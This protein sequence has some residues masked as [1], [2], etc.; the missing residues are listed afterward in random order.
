MIALR[1]VYVLALVVWLGGTV[2]IGGVV[3]PAAFAALEAHDPAGGRT[4]AAVVVGEVLRRF[5]VVSWIALPALL[6]TLIAM[7]LVGPRP[8]GFGVR[9]AIVSVL[10]ALSLISG[11][12]IDPEIAAL[13]RAAGVPMQELDAADP[14]R[15]RFNTLHGLSTALMTAGALGGLVLCFW[16]TRE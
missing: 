1:Y 3:A 4:A 8:P 12:Y 14:R 6:V 7:K 13:R 11:L 10:I 16:E 9:V 5:R 15:V 2:T